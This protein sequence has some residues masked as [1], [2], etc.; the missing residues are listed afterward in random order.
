VI[1]PGEARRSYAFTATAAL[2]RAAN[3]LSSEDVSTTADQLIRTL[4]T[5]SESYRWD[6]V[7]EALAVAWP[8][9]TPERRRDALATVRDL[10][11]Q[12]LRPP[13]QD[14][15]PMD[16]RDSDVAYVVIRLAAVLD[17]E[18]RRR[19]L[20]ILARSFEAAD[21][22][23]FGALSDDVVRLAELL[24]PDDSRV[25]VE[26]VLHALAGR[27]RT[28]SVQDM[29]SLFVRLKGV[30]ERPAQALVD[31]LKW[32][33]LHPEIRAAL[34]AALAEATGEDATRLASLNRW[35]FAGWAL[36][37]GLDLRPPRPPIQ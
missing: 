1:R 8:R 5:P 15:P 26:S 37:K 19:A 11:A 20:P 14:G 30:R 33:I 12:A 24:P 36:A 4:K 23:L 3:R 34:T 25:V 28:E 17:P 2:A 22:P 13:P 27:F 9:L 10:I 35:Q 16:V 6:E 18:D 21:P 32:P 29:I 31:A 7:S